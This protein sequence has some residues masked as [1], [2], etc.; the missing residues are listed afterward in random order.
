V[1]STRGS[2]AEELWTQKLGAHIDAQRAHRKLYYANRRLS[3]KQPENVLTIIHDKMDHLKTTSPHFSHKNKAVD[4]FMKL[5]VAITGM[6]AHGHGDCRYAHYG[7]DIYPSDSNHTVGSIAKLLW[8]L[9]LPPKYS[10]RELFVGGRSAPVL[11]ALLKGANKYEGSLPPP[12]EAPVAAVP[13]PPVLN[14]QLDN[15]TRNNKNHY[16]FSFCSLLVHRGVFWEV[17]INFLLVG[18]THEDIDALFGRWSWKLKAN[19]Y[20]TLPWSCS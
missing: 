9:E 18:H 12:L 14:L 19:D 11:E 6:I 17:Y 5:P 3:E 15:A 1:A 10:S 13:L 20:P 8:D 4:S 16:V 7:L 2:R